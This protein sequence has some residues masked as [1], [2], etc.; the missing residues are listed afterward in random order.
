MND[1]ILGIITLAFCILGYYLSYQYQKKSNYITAVLLLM[2]CGMALRLF[3]SADFFLH[4]WDEVFH[5]VASKHLMHHPFIP[6][7]YD[8]PVLPYDYK[9]WTGNHIWVH[10]QPLPLWTIALSMSIGGINEI[11]LRFPSVLLTT[12]AIWLTYYIGTYFYDKKVGYL[13]AFLFSINGLIIELAAG[14]VPTDHIDVFFLL[15]VELSVFFSIIFIRKKSF[16]FI[17]LTGLS[18]GGAILCKWLPAL[19]VLPIWL[20]IAIDSKEFSIKAIVLY[21]LALVCIAVCVFLPW[22]IYIH[23][24]FPIESNWESGYNMKHITE[25]L[26]NQ[27]GPLYYYLNKIRI[28]YG[29]LIYLPLIWFC[30]LV[31]KDYR[32][33]KRLAL[34]IWCYIPIIFFSLIKTK[35]QGYILFASPAIFIISAAFWYALYERQKDMATGIKNYKLQKWGSLLLL[36]LLIGLPVRY[37]IERVKPFQKNRSPQWVKDLKTLEQ[38]N[39]KTGVLFN[40]DKPI[41]AM[42]YTDL[43]VYSSIPDKNTIEEL[44][45]KGL[46]ILINDNGNIPQDIISTPQII[47]LHLSSN[48]N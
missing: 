31:L 19:I 46:T 7:L 12:I 9:N 25:V 16:L 21:F 36:I 42:F 32:N 8:T 13:A 27:G 29:E 28:N 41:D 23:H 37:C 30:W 2:L 6:T 14:R 5:A 10:K 17:F 40:Y 3:T 44:Q 33:S 47:V 18:I 34:F 15:F 43:T 38:R 39:L 1:Q 20:L 26:D 45:K 24:A 4:S 22:Q 35:M 48:I 11:A